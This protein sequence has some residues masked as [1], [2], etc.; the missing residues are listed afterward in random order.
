MSVSQLSFTDSEIHE[1]VTQRVS[2]H[3][4]GPVAFYLRPVGFQPCSTALR[5]RFCACALAGVVAFAL[6]PFGVE[7]RTL[8]FPTVFNFTGITHKSYFFLAFCP[9]VHF[10][11]SVSLTPREAQGVQSPSQLC[12]WVLPH[13][14]HF[15][16]DVSVSASKT[17]IAAS[18]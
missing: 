2:L 9:A 3:Q 13:C 11:R 12:G 14:E 10:G 4:F 18:I 16:S 6:T 1:G 15:G 7:T 17:F 5:R 8:P